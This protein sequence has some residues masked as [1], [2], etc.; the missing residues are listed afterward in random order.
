MPRAQ[1]RTTDPRTIRRRIYAGK[2]IAARNAGMSWDEIERRLGIKT[3]TARRILDEVMEDLCPLEDV[4][5]YRRIQIARY[6]ELYK[7]RHARAVEEGDDNAFKLAIQALAG[8]DKIT[9][10]AGGPPKKK[11]EVD[12]EKEA[13]VVAA[14]V[15]LVRKFRLEGGSAEPVQVESG[16]ETPAHLQS[17]YNKQAAVVEAELV[18]GEDVEGEDV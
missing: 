3:F 5:D 12:A 9:G 18:E 4:E 10:L 1:S 6:E 16:Y 13:S 14:A 11:E 17:L 7:T 2:L 8:L 15:E